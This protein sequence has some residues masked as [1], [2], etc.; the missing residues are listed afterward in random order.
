MTV[1]GRDCFVTRSGYT[2]EDGFEIQVR[3]RQVG[4]RTSRHTRI[5][6]VPIH[7]HM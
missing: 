5:P 7:A 6:K 3:R 4:S 1:D 2:G